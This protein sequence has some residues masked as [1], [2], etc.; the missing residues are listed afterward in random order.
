VELAA[1][2]ALEGAIGFRFRDQTLLR[3]ALTHSS[4]LNENPACTWGDNERLEFLG[5][6]VVDFL[7]ADLIFGRYPEWEEGELTSLR[8]EMV[9]ADSLARFAIE[10]GLGAHLNLGR[11]EEQSGGRNRPALLGDAFEALVGAVYLEGGMEA[12]SGFVLPFLRGFLDGRNGLLKRD[13]KSRLQEWSQANYKSTPSYVI[14]EETGPDHARLFTVEVQ[15]RGDARGRGTGRSKQAAEQAAAEA[16]LERCPDGIT[17]R[18]ASVHQGPA[19][20]L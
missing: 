8:A 19:A 10:L 15:I 7:A 13:A 9:R 12:A 4:F 2:G 11:G 20:P 3:R 14:V 16:A 1:V 17:R 5:D 6:A 18:L